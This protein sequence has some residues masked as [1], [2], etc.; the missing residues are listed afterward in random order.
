MPILSGSAVRPKQVKKTEKSELFPC[1]RRT[2]IKNVRHA[3]GLEPNLTRLSSPRQPNVWQNAPLFAA[4]AT[5]L[6]II[7]GR[8]YGF[9]SRVARRWRLVVSDHYYCHPRFVADHSDFAE[10]HDRKANRNFARSFV[11]GDGQGINSRVPF[12]PL[13]RHSY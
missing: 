2:A 3:P 11:A 5:P 1:A 8:M 9:P 6:V 10:H 7:T 4:D 12:K 13:T